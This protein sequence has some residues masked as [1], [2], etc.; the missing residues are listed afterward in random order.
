MLGV[1]A[2]L[3]TDSRMTSSLAGAWTPISL[4]GKNVWATKPQ[5][6]RMTA[7]NM[8]AI[9]MRIGRS[10]PEMKRRRYACFRPAASGRCGSG[11]AV[12][13]Q[14]GQHDRDGI[15]LGSRALGINGPPV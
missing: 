12:F 1:G 6:K 14:L 9:T 3:L 7:L 8:A 10:S 13:V 4:I 15:E 5:M 2:P 11:L